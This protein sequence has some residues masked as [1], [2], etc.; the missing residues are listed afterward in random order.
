MGKSKDPQDPKPR[1]D[2]PYLAWA[3]ATD[4]R[5]LGRPAKF[6]LLLRLNTTAKRFA[7]IAKEFPPDVITVPSVFAEPPAGLEDATFCTASV[8]EAFFKPSESLAPLMGLIES[9]A[10]GLPGLSL[11]NLPPPCLPNPNLLAK[12]VVTAVMDDGLAFA[13]RRFLRADG[14]SRVEYLWKQ[15]PP[16]LVLTRA[17]INTALGASTHGGLLDEDEVYRKLLFENAAVSGHKPLARRRAHGT[18]VMDLACGLDATMAMPS[19]PIIGVQFPNGVIQD[20]SGA[21]LLPHVYL[22]LWF[23]LY[24]ADLI[25]CAEGS[26]PLPVAVNIS[27]GRFADSHDGKSN[28]ELAMDELIQL[29]RAVAPFAVV[30]PSGNSFLARCHA[31]LALAPGEERTL[32]WR[33][34]P[35]DRTPSFLQIWPGPVNASGVAPDLEVRVFSPGGSVPVMSVT[36][37]VVAP[38]PM[39]VQVLARSQYQPAGLPPQPHRDRIDVQLAPTTTHNPIEGVAP[40][41]TWKVVIKNKGPSYSA[42]INAWVQR[43]DTPYGWPITGRQSRFD[44]RDYPRFDASGR[45]VRDQAAGSEL[46]IDSLASRVKHAGSIN[47]IATGQEPVVI[48]AFRASD[49]YAAAYSAGGPLVSPGTRVG[50]DPDAMAVGDDSLTCTGVLA[51]GTRSG[52]VVSMNGTSVAAPQITRWLANQMAAGLPADRSAVQGLASVMDPPPPAPTVPVERKG[53]G[54]TDVRPPPRVPRR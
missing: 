24:C 43:D 33:V 51:A 40:A 7:G 37:G 29:R 45:Y 46:A 30:L 8:S 44:D 1:F 22:G 35:D 14:T 6:P 42:E 39:S 16:G 52:S 32:H 41:G 13:H 12:H 34:Q 17:D 54:R 49:R 5:Y 53:A 38:W 3:F 4:F 2:D 23:V 48:G 9:I 27:Y 47:A 36:R 11:P 28:H 26:G 15:D 25:A 10:F 19:P 18:H 50:F 31:Q 21:S 20:T